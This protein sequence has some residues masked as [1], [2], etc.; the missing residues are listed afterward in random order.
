[1]LMLVG[2]Y[3]CG[4]KSVVVNVYALILLYNC[5][6]IMFVLFYD[7]CSIRVYQSF[8]AIFQ[9]ISYYAGIIL[10]DFSDLYNAQNYAGIIGWPLSLQ[11][12]NIV[13]FIKLI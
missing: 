9:N 3:L 7:G 6:K 1:M 8:V 13:T 4:Q 10:N 2:K 12:C 11:Q 5:S